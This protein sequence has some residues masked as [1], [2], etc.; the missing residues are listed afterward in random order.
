M[1]NQPIMIALNKLKLSPLNV[2]KTPATAEEDNE[3]YASI[4]AHGI[5]QNLLVYKSGSTYLVHA[6]GRRLGMCQR[7][8]EEGEWPADTEV[9]CI[10]ETKKQAEETSLI[11]NY[12]R[13]NMHRA[14][15]FLAFAELVD[16]GIQIDEIAKRFGVTVNLVERRLKLARVAPQIL[17]AFRNNEMTLDCVEAFTVSDDHARQLEVWN[18]VSNQYHFSSHNIRRMLTEKTYSANSRLGRFVG[19]DAYREAG[20]IVIE[21]LFSDHNNMHL[22]DSALVERL[23]NDKLEEAAEELRKT[24]KWAEARLEV[25]YEE[26]RRFGRVY[27]LQLDLEPAIAEELTT[28]RQRADELESDYDEDTWTDELQ[29]E[30][31]RIFCRIVEIEDAQHCN[32]SFTDE[33]R[34]IAG[35]IVTIDHGGELKV[36]HG[37]VRPEDIPEQPAEEEVDQE[38]AAIEISMPTAS[39]KANTPVDPLEVARKEQGISISLAEDLRA[40]RHQILKAH[41]AADYET[42]FDVM[43]YS[44]CKQVLQSGYGY[45]SKP[46]NVSLTPAEVYRSKEVLK[47]TVAESMLEATH[48]RLNLSWVSLAK[49]ADFEA[50]SALPAGD[51]Q[52]LFAWCTAHALVQQLSTDNGAHPVVEL[53]GRRMNVDVAACWRPTAANYWG[54]VK[55]GHALK[56]ARE[57]ISDR[58]ADDKANE[59]KAEIA[60]SM[61]G[62]FS[63]EAETRAGMTPDAAA[64]TTTWLPD[65]MAFSDADTAQPASTELSDVEDDEAEDGDEEDIPA[66]LKDAAE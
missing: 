51:K 28:L 18:A 61:E 20:G 44:M 10:V 36:E 53:I 60:N 52:A 45:E 11:E 14:D 27:P 13:A 3:L 33:Q 16:K 24:W 55:K 32:V 63:E 21:D 48:D 46:I 7:L 6:G 59:K 25:E 57:L 65:G 64:R 23:A 50:L 66:F 30:E 54:R 29:E 58:W 47:D 34:A 37:L 42:A 8:V 2:R 4:K 9:P 38:S 19:I 41:L 62:A 5:K 26:Y 22:K 1:T 31:D 39:R 40:S 49:P 15:E 12:A 17:D 56:V 35:C 43:L